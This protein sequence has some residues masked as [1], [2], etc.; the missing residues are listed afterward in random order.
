MVETSLILC[1][2]MPPPGQRQTT[3][4]Q[5]IL[6]VDDEIELLRGMVAMLSRL[7]YKSV[8]AAYD[9]ADAWEVLHKVKYSLVI[10]DHK[11]PRITGLELIARMRA[12]GLSQPVILMSGT[13]PADELNRNP[14]LRVDAMLTKPFSFAELTTTIDRLLHATDSLVI[15]KMDVLSR[16]GEPTTALTR[17]RKCP[18]HRILVVDD[19]PSCRQLHIDL[20]ISSGYR[21][22]AANDGAAGWEA[23]RSHDYDLVITD[24]HM[25]RMTGIEMLENLHLTG[26]TVPVIM[27]TGQLPTEEFARKPWLKPEALLQKPVTDRD[28]LEAISN[29]LETDVGKGEHQE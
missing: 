6:V 15:G 11:M 5:S 28:L 12:E 9:G 22:E 3:S 14:G 10:T 24:N 16:A 4:S 20:L 23:L 29:I 17:G 26:M 25:P 2:D 27:A 18:A 19:D 13:M 8:D 1:S 21:V 7:G